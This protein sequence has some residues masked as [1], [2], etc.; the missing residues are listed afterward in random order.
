MFFADE[1]KRKREIN[2]QE[3]KPAKRKSVVEL[4]SE[5]GDV[6][7]VALESL[8][9]LDP[10]EEQKGV[11]APNS[12]LVDTEECS[13]TNTSPTESST[14]S[15]PETADSCEPTDAAGIGKF[16]IKVKMSSRRLWRT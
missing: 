2:T 3:E 6:D 13:T 7:T 12:V 5:A 8:T 16:K 15:V 1:G 10:V 14:G 9:V 4:E 11:P